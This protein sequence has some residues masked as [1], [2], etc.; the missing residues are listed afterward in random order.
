MSRCLAPILSFVPQGTV[1]TEPGPYG[2]NLTEAK[3]D[4]SPLGGCR[5]RQYLFQN[6]YAF[7][8]DDSFQ[9]AYQNRPTPYSSRLFKY[10]PPAG[11]PKWPSPSSD[12]TDD[13]PPSLPRPTR[14]LCLRFGRGGRLLVDWRDTVPRRPVKKYARSSLFGLGDEDKSEGEDSIRRGT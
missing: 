7:D 13:S 1:T 8:P 5:R 3:G 9:N 6:K 11:A 10:F 14:A 4:R 12:K 2:G